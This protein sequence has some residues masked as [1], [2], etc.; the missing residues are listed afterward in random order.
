MYW[1][2]THRNYDIFR[3]ESRTKAFSFH[4]FLGPH[5]KVCIADMS[6][7][8]N[9][10][11]ALHNFLDF[12]SLENETF[13]TYPERWIIG[14]DRATLGQFSIHWKF[15]E[16]KGGLVF[17]RNTQGLTFFG[18]QKI[19]GIWTHHLD[20]VW[21]SIDPNCSAIFGFKVIR[22]RCTCPLKQWQQET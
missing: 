18:G 14:W 8:T 7:N 5:Q 1:I 19:I 6:G 15:P 3:R 11:K 21:Y 13:F 12:W 16:V 20:A 2:V 9:W 4:W 10:R 17:V 22:A